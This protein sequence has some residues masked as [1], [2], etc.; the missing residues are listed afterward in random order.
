MS[1]IN[2]KTIF[3]RFI[4]LFKIY[5][6]VIVIIYEPIIFSTPKN[7]KY[8]NSNNRFKGRAGATITVKIRTNAVI[9]SLNLFVLQI[10]ISLS[11]TDLKLRL[12]KDAN[13][14]N[15]VTEPVYV[16]GP[17]PTEPDVKFTCFQ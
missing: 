13:N 4:T 5:N 17:N 8:I 16:Q 14:K 7:F 12:R 1:I 10:P 3:I 11:A 9:F 2:C 6:F 15:Y